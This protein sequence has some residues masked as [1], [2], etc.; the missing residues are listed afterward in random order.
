[1][2]FGGVVVDADFF[3]SAYERVILIKFKSETLLSI[4]SDR[5]DI[6]DA[7]SYFVQYTKD[8][9]IAAIHDI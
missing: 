4:F 1:M 3:M 7:V 8:A 6:F 9:W 5:S 2:S